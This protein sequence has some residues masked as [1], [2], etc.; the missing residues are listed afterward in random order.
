MQTNFKKTCRYFKIYSYF[1]NILLS[2]KGIAALLLKFYFIKI[3][4]KKILWKGVFLRILRNF[5]EHLFYRTPLVNYFG[6]L[7]GILENQHNRI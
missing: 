1:I 3:L 6:T 5:Q 7:R 4:L 2:Q